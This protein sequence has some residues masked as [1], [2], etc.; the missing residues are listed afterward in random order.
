MFS[1]EED[2]PKIGV[3]SLNSRDND[4]KSARNGLKLISAGGVGIEGS[5]E[6]LTLMRCQLIHQKMNTKVR[7]PFNFVIMHI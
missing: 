1:Q 7:M 2:C 6:G 3:S 5:Q 4:K